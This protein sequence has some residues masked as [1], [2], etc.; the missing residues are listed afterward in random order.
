MEQKEISGKVVVITGASSGVG[1]ATAVAF[2]RK[3]AQVVLGARREEALAEVVRECEELGA[4]ARYVVTDVTDIQ[5]VQAL[6]AAAIDFAGR[7]D[8][9]VN[10]AGVLNVGSFTD[11]PAA[12]HDRVVEVNLMGY[13]HGAYAALP[14][15]K[16]QE[17]GVLI[18]NISVGAWTPTPYAVGYAASKF[19]LRGFSQSLRGEL[20]SFPHIY[21]CDLFPGF[22]DTPGVQH[23]G[24]Y[25]GVALQP[26]PPVYDPQRV[27]RA[28][29]TLA[30][31]PRNEEMVG[32]SALFLRVA[33]FLFPSLTARIAAGVMESYFKH[34]DPIEST[35]GNLFH[36]VE[37]GTSI[38]GG[39]RLPSSPR[40]KALLRSLLA[41]GLATGFLLLARKR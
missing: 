16:S 39:W 33:H 21:V 4:K 15:F 23:A 29:V 12:A 38:H 35:G 13:L 19:G 6:A 9:W 5:Q 8:V 28:I 7:I 11:T 22:L 25:T 30:A 34:A 26:A 24:N 36:P 41:V 1:R 31:R 27:A 20:R 32:S 14:Y 18:N 17:Y 3:G 10:N 40:K 37:Y 2:A